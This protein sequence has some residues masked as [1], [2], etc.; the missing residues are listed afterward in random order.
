MELK[1]A[2]NQT[3]KKVYQAPKLKKYG[4]VSKLTLKTGS[5]TD[6]LGGMGVEF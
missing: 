3:Q 6:G 1:N 5:D 2:S 4:S